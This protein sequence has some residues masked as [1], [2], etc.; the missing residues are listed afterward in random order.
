MP[1]T[2]NAL[3]RAVDLAIVLLSWLQKTMTPATPH[4]PDLPGEEVTGD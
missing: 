4:S 2:P 3:R 1:W